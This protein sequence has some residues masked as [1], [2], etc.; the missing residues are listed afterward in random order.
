[1][2]C[3]PGSAWC[4]AASRPLGRALQIWGH[5][6]RDRQQRGPLEPFGNP[7]EITIRVRRY[8]LRGCE[9]RSLRSRRLQPSESLLNRG[10]DRC[11]WV[12]PH[13][14]DDAL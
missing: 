13:E 1:M 9:V 3:G 6:L 14:F 5:G 8:Q 2:R 4:A 10:V 12:R 7:V 11:E